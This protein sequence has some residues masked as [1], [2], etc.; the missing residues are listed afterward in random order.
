MVAKSLAH[1]DWGKVSLTAL[2]RNE[3]DLR[4][5]ATPRRSMA[6]EMQATDRLQASRLVVTHQ[7]RQMLVLLQLSHW[8]PVL[9]TVC[10]TWWEETA[11]A[12][13]PTL[14]TYSH[15]IL[16]NVFLLADE[17]TLVI[18]HGF[19]RFKYTTM[20]RM[21]RRTSVFRPLTLNVLIR[22]IKNQLPIHCN[23]PFENEWSDTSDR[24]KKTLLRQLKN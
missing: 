7:G 24:N 17:Y 21:T 9:I 20:V 15:F 22:T 13:L 19:R 3:T 8:W 23:R 10:S 12:S 11:L 16:F 4:L 6:S 5:G 1:H 14:Y 18:L 2:C